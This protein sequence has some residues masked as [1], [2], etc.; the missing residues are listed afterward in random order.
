MA[1]VMATT[2]ASLRRWTVRQAEPAE[3]VPLGRPPVL[4]EDVREQLRACYREHYGQ[5][6]PRV[7]A[8]WARRQGLGHFSPTTIAEAVADLRPE[9]DPTPR[10]Q[11]YRVTAP[12]VLWSDDGAGFREHGQKHEALLL[13]DECSRFKVGH[14]LVAG[15]ARGADVAE[16][17][18]AAFRRQGAPLVLKRDNGAVLHTDEV[19][20]LLDEYGVVELTSPPGYPQYNGKTERTVRDV[21]SFMRAMRAVHRHSPLPVRFAAALHDLNVDRPR[22][23][24]GGRTAAEVFR[25]DRRSLPD[26]AAFRSA[27]FRREAEL[28]E[29]AC[30]RHAEAAARRRAVTEVLSTYGL[31]EN[32]VD[33]SSDSAGKGWTD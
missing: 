25:E 2:P 1:A 15:P 20:R 33:V 16:C 9:P 6:G 30:S 17:L 14:R 23:V 3:P 7:L 27:V 13:S 29:G 12:M 18:R 8:H 24:L 21:K 11:R 22:P 19:S 31:L 32:V 5:W 26:R 10:P 4:S 28:I